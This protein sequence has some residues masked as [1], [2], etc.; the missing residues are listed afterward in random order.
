MAE[1]CVKFFEVF[2][3]KNPEQTKFVLDLFDAVQASGTK[4]PQ[5]VLSK[6]EEAKAS[7]VAEPAAATTN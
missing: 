7:P 6:L 2:Q 5:E 4:L 3:E 1:Y